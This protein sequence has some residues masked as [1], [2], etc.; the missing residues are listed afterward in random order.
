MFAVALQCYL[1]GMVWSCYQFILKAQMRAAG[2]SEV[3]TVSYDMTTAASADA[4]GVSVFSCRRPQVSTPVIPD[5][6]RF[7]SARLLL[8][9][10]VLLP[11]K[12]EDASRTEDDVVSGPAPPPYVG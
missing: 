4:T 11:P 10:Q 1:M 12:Y 5:T 8:L 6:H 7:T 3:G 2:N 9:L